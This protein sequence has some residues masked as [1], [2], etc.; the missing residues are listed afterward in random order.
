MQ[1]GREGALP[2]F[3]LENTRGISGSPVVRAA[4]M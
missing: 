4:A 1:H 3:F 2:G